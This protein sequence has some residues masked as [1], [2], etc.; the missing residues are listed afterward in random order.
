MSDIS[1][2]PGWWQASDR[3]WYPPERHSDYVA[4]PP[5]PPRHD[6]TEASGQAAGIPTGPPPRAWPAPSPE[7]GAVAG[8]MTSDSLATAKGIAAKLS[9]TAWLLI[10]GFVVAII[11]VFLAWE[12]T[13]AWVAVVLLVAIAV[14]AWLAWPVFAGYSMSIRRLAGLSVLASLLV[15]CSVATFIEDASVGFAG[16]LYTAAV[17]AIVVGVVRIWI[18][19][20]KTQGRA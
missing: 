9:A 13:A 5:P 10:G 17:I 18:H 19:R 3:K 8:Q 2:G 4:P 20:A 6:V 7:T 12:T 1:Q 16:W 14:A 15:F 11:S